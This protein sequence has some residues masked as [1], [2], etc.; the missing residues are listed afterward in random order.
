M[1]VSIYHNLF[2]TA[3]LCDR[4]QGQRFITPDRHSQGIHSLR[5][6]ILENKQLKCP[7]LIVMVETGGTQK[8]DVWSETSVKG[9]TGVFLRDT[10]VKAVS[11]NGSW[12]QKDMEV[13]NNVVV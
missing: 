12:V 2:S 1:L 13:L 4:L 5:E 10:N 11:T 3:K 8:A 7:M 6:I 9:C